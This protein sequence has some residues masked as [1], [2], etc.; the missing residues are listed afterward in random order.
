MLRDTPAKSF[1][2]VLSA[3]CWLGLSTSNLFAQVTFD[4]ATVGNP[5]NA[6]DQLYK[7]NNSGNLLFGAVAD[8]YR[9]SKHEVTNDQ[10]TEFLNAVADTD[11]NGLYNPS[12]GSD[13][14]ALG[15]IT[16]S[17]SSGSFSYLDLSVSGN[18]R[19][20]GLAKARENFNSSLLSMLK[21]QTNK[22]SGHG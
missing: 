1:M 17:G 7:F 16:Q 5:N 22:G 12:M 2:L 9:I 19:Q 8:V 10:Y 21:V 15:G 18:R 4:W 3:A 13:A 6:P 20:A 14:H 11:T